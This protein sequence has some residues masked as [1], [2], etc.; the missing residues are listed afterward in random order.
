MMKNVVAVG[1][2]VRSNRIAQGM[3]ARALSDATDLTEK[4]VYNIEH[5][6]FEGMKAKSL[7]DICC[8]LK[9]DLKELVE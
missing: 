5:G 1:L 7:I 6:K 2:L 8:V 4:T 9:I 3:T